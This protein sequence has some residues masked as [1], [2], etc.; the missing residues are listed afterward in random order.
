[1]AQPVRLAIVKMTS[2]GLPV[3]C[4]EILKLRN[5]LTAC[6]IT[7]VQPARDSSY[8][9]SKLIGPPSLYTDVE[10]SR[11]PE[12]WKFVERLLPKTFIPEPTLKSDYPSG[13]K[14]PTESSCSHPYFVE[15]NRNHMYPLYLKIQGRGER[16]TTKLKRIQGD[17]WALHDDLKKYLEDRSKKYVYLQIQEVS[18]HINI[19]GDYVSVVEEWLQDKGF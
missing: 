17:I 6:F 16:K 1:M 7:P 9:G 18:G 2:R 14:P 12:E 13:W 3:R 10:I 5:A 11:S 8:Q 15:R 19:K 4:L